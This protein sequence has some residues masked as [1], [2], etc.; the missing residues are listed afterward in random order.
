MH[1]RLFPRWIII[2][3]FVLGLFSALCFRLIIFVNNFWPDYSRFVWYLGIGGY[4]LFFSF[5]FY[6]SS[7]RRK[8]IRQ[9]AL[10]Q[11]IKKN[12]LEETD[13]QEIEYLL[14]SLMKSREMYNYIF[15]F[16][17][18]GI[19]VLADVILSLLIK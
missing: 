9:N 1:T 15:I 7:K 13:R 16:I 18:S 12:C 17:S 5:R 14:N 3:F 11:K 6:I 4:I 8:T 19:A 10:I 2:F